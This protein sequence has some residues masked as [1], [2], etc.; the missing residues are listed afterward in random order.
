M[1][2]LAAILAMASLLI[3]HCLPID[4]SRFA[5]ADDNKPAVLQL[6]K[7]SKV[8]WSWAEAYESLQLA[9]TDPYLQYIT[10]QLASNEKDKRATFELLQKYQSEDMGQLL[11]LFVSSSDVQRMLQGALMTADFPKAAPNT[12]ENQAD[13]VVNAPDDVE[14]KANAPDAKAPAAPDTKK[15]ATP[16]PKKPA[17]K[18]VPEKEP[19]VKT[20]D[21]PGPTVPATDWTKLLAGRK[22][23]VSELSR[24]VPQDF[25][26]IEFKSPG[27]LFEACEFFELVASQ[28]Q[29][30]ALQSSTTQEVGKRLRR[31]LAFDLDPQLRPFLD[32]VVTEVAVCGS[33][34]Y[35]RNG[36]DVT[37]LVRFNQPQLFQSRIADSFTKFGEKV[38][39]TKLTSGNYRGVKYEQLTTPDRSI[40]AISAFPR[41]G[42]L[43]RSNSLTAFQKVI[44]AIEGKTA[45]GKAVPRLGESAEYQYFRT[46]FPRNAKEEDGF[47]YFSDT[48]LRRIIGS[49][50]KLSAARRTQCQACLK[51]I[52][53]GA[54]LHQTQY[55]TKPGSLAE[56]N[57]HQCSPGE[58]GRERLV[59]P[60]GGTYSLGQDGLTGVCSHHGSL[61]YSVP[62]C[63]SPVNAATAG[64]ARGY[65]GYVSHLSTAW[66]HF[67]SPLAIRLQITPEKV[68]AESLF[69]PWG[70]T[71]GIFKEMFQMNPWGAAEPLQPLPTVRGTIVTLGIKLDKEALL[72]KQPKLAQE[73]WP[74]GEEHKPHD[75]VMRKFLSEGIGNQIQVHYCDS[76]PAFDFSLQK[77]TSRLIGTVLGVSHQQSFDIDLYYFAYG[78]VLN[79]P[80]YLSIP[81]KNAA[82]VD[83]FLQSVDKSLIALT[84]KSN[85]NVGRN[86]M[87][88]DY[89]LFDSP[90]LQNC[91][92]AAVTAGSGR[93]RVFWARIGNGLYAATRR[94]ILEELAELERT[95]AKDAPK[96]VAADAGPSGHM[97]VRL[98]HRNLQR[99]LSMRGLARAEHNRGACLR[100]VMPL[101][102]VARALV[103]SGVSPSDS[104]F[105]EQMIQQ[106]KRIQNAHAV[107]PDGGHYQVLPDG[108]RVECTAHGSPFNP[109][110]R[111]VPEDDS[112]VARF[113][114]QLQELNI[115]VNFQEE[116][117]RALVTIDRRVPQTPMKGSVKGTR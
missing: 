96:Q 65:R 77:L 98:Q 3:A 31:Q 85:T 94:E 46:Q 82:H 52:G 59:C 110:Q 23:E 81:V 37:L 95:P 29:V 100:N 103:A 106:A 91:R 7:K 54:M 1:P 72:A 93:L 45:A 62:C 39:D 55:G 102:Y 117:M 89:Y 113:A 30:Q 79:S 92:C 8:A 61:A 49:E 6:P 16:D 50:V 25:Y 2:R 5:S 67:V 107:C 97:I 42:V 35:V 80:T 21:L 53:H 114:Q 104:K 101:S 33:N 19:D 111:H 78:G 11:N 38:A 47:L 40:S 27:K 108:T 63:D 87:G 32:L 83:R 74:F 60:Q 112:A 36:S 75:V 26:L 86:E 84:R 68:R 57:A 115:S 76:Y 14:V 56:L 88:Y 70:A 73:L 44:D 9:P 90:K 109:R 13:K 105:D 51:M 58:F 28:F 116:G 18:P 20:L 24:F 10:L 48:F 71:S 12:E 66:Q 41:D 22:P 4:S 17:Q 99:A 43:V 69:V 64:E 34:L 15:P